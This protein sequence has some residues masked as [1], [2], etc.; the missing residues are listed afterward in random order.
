MAVTK[1][2]DGT[3]TKRTGKK[4]GGEKIVTEEKK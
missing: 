1:K 3:T 2:D 4:I